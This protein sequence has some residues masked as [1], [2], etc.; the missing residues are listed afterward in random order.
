MIENQEEEEDDEEEMEIED[1]D[2]SIMVERINGNQKGEAT[3]P[4]GN[5][6]QLWPREDLLVL[7]N[8]IEQLIPKQDKLRFKS[9]LDR[10]NWNDVIFAEYSAEDCRQMW[11]YVQKHLRYVSPEF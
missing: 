11:D 1:D 3:T 8:K 9:R 5:N 4:L 2:E 10:I 7:F 6:P